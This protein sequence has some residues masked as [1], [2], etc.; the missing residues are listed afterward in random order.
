MTITTSATGGTLIPEDKKWDDLGA[1]YNQYGDFWDRKPP[2][3]DDDLSRFLQPL[4]SGMSGIVGNL[5]L[6]RWQPV[7]SNMQAQNINWMAFGVD[8]LKSDTYSAIIHASKTYEA[9][10]AKFDDGSRYSGDQDQASG[11]FDTGQTFD[12]SPE[13]YDVSQ[14]QYDKPDAT[15]DDGQTFDI[16]AAALQGDI[17]YHQEE[18]GVLCTFYGPSCMRNASRLRDGWQIAQNREALQLAGM[19]FI[20]AGDMIQV[21]ELV[22]NIWVRRIDLLLN[23]RRAV[24]RVYPVLDILELSGNDQLVT[25]VSPLTR[26]IKVTLPNQQ[27]V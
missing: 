13:P 17:L 16:N 5:V 20:D 7:P 9:P 27:G 4:F 25:D 11:D 10:G 1:K 26:N 23:F 15:L 6:P 21:P 8:N 2:H 24:V 22:N 12:A 18:I 3:Y 19:G 14:Q